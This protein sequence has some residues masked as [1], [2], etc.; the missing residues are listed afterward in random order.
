M[1]ITK[2]ACKTVI[3]RTFLQASSYSARRIQ[4]QVIGHLCERR[5]IDFLKMMD[6]NSRAFGCIHKSSLV[7]VENK[8]SIFYYLNK[9][10]VS[11]A[12]ACGYYQVIGSRQQYKD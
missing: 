5:L 11:T 4:S 10:G 8:K 9:Q 7:L 6:A 12:N 3:D 1:T 2:D